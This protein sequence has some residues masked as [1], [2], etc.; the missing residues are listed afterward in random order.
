MPTSTDVIS[1][2]NKLY[3]TA[4]FEMFF[5]FSLQE[6]AAALQTDC[7]SQIKYIEPL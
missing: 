6:V 5:P 7:K 3:C 2:F 1:L 4:N